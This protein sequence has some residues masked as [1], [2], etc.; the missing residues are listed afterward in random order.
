MGPRSYLNSR[1]GQQLWRSLRGPG[2]AG[3]RLC[4]RVKYLPSQSSCQYF[5]CTD[6]IN[7]SLTIIPDLC[8][9][10]NSIPAHLLNEFSKYLIQFP[11]GELWISEPGQLRPKLP[12]AQPTSSY[13]ATAIMSCRLEKTV[14]F[15]KSLFGHVL[16][17][18]W[19]YLM[20]STPK[21]R[22]NC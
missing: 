13:L 9:C 8:P 15:L 19:T 18:P 20:L 7:T 12:S 16:S 17:T 2:Q 22:V 11:D 10:T 14:S 21:P 1:H 4:Q 5:S 6:Y 3:R